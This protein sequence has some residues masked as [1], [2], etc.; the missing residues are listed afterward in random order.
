MTNHEIDILVD[1]QAE[2]ETGL[3]WTFLEVN[4][5]FLD[6]QASSA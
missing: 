6:A 1:L 3:P 4:R 5:H 2:D